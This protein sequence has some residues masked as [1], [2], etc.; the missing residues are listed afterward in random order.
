MSQRGL[1]IIVAIIGL[2]VASPAADVLSIRLVP[3]E[4]QLAGANAT[5]RI[6]VIGKFTDGLER[7]IT[8][9]SRI[10][11]LNP[12]LARVEQ[13]AR[14][15]AISDG[16]TEVTATYKSFKTQSKL[17][18]KDSQRN[19]AF[20]FAW[21]IGEVLTRRGCNDIAC[22]GSVVGRGGFKLSVDGRYPEE[23]YNWILKGGIYTVFTVAPKAPSPPRVNL[24]EPEK[25]LLLMK[26]TLA[27]PHGG[28]KV[29]SPADADYATLL[30]W[31][32]KGAPYGEPANARIKDLE[33]LPKE[34]VLD[35]AGSQQFLV[36]AHLSN[37]QT[38]DVTGQVRYTLS[39][40][41]IANVTGGGLVKPKGAGET[42]V[43]VHAAG[44]AP[45]TAWL[46]VI[47]KP[48]VNYPPVAGR[49]LIDDHIFGKLRS[50]SIIPSFRLVFGCRISAS[51]LPGCD[52]DVASSGARPQISCRQRSE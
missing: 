9:E 10:A 48:V 5:Q 44:Q 20:Q 28:G 3:D 25:S 42:A 36:T 33:V 43:I 39:N 19:R 13:G 47:A 24:N 14:V 15:V 46:G 49:N 27:T 37:G 17:R 7:D 4:I 1:S 34:V 41:Q 8:S 31:I 45:I 16:G 26:P 52:R 12:A 51:R 2:S 29:F 38:E 35:L 23:D 32:Q 40:N 6:L 18:V 11:V 21:D 50:L 30:N 22:H